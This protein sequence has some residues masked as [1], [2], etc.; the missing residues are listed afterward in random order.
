[1]GY[2]K[3]FPQID[4]N[5]G[6]ETYTTRFQNL[7]VYIDLLDR[8]KEDNSFYELY[9]I[10]EGDRPDVLSHKLYGTSN[11]Y[12][13]FFFIND[14][15]REF[16][17]PTTSSR[18]R[19]YLIN[20]YNDTVITSRDPLYGED[21][22]VGNEIIGG[23][24]GTIATIKSKTLDLGQI[25]V[26]GQHI[27]QDGETIH[28]NDSDQTPLFTVHSYSEQYNSA[29]YY[30]KDDEQVDIDPYIGPGAELREVTFLDYY[31]EKNEQNREI[32]ILKEDVAKQIFLA[33]QRELGTNG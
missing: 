6:D 3:A 2:F 4:Y 18:L 23:T 14:N 5:F 1:M 28:L 21:I 26:E 25:L 31:A 7:S 9:T 13:T 27:F 33:H 30:T 32:K 22:K 17:W 19:E 8:L 24:S 15:L 16:G 11:F 20:K 12:W 29:I 10:L